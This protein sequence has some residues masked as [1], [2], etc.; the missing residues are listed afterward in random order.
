MTPDERDDLTLAVFLIALA[1]FVDAVGFL[2]LGNLFVSF[3]SGNSTQFA[4]WSEQGTWRL[5]APAAL[6]VGLFVVGVM[7]G[8]GIATRAGRGRRPA[9]LIVEAGLLGL[10]AW[11]PLPALAAGASMTVAMG[12]QNGVLHAAGRTRTPL[13]YIT[14]SL[15][16]FGETLADTLFGAERAS[17]PWP[18]LALWLGM[19]F[20]G[21]AG[22]VA[23]ATLGVRALTLPALAA[24]LLAAVMA[25][26]GWAA[27]RRH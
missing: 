3:M 25:V 15:V 7:L 14:G 13:T 20:G 16:N 24:A 21:A 22:A 11:A 5:A 12:A 4:I 8:R 2:M 9:I 18:Y 6:I 26:L 23:F 19:V 1:G 27:S 17:A 10:A